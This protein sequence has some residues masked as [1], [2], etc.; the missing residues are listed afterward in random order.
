MGIYCGSAQAHYAINSGPR[1]GAEGEG[2][3]TDDDPNEAYEV[4][5]FD[6]TKLRLE[7]LRLVG[8]PDRQTLGGPTNA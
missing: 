7:R 3:M 8:T 5:P 2:E 6:R 1:T 4:V